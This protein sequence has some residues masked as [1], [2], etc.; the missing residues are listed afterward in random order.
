MGN[1]AL[2]AVAFDF[3]TTYSGYAFSF[4]NDPLNVQHNQ[5]WIAGSDRLISVKTPTCV[6]LNPS[7]QFDSFGY[8]AENNYAILA[9]NNKHHGWLLFRRFKMILHSS[10]VN[11]ITKCFNLNTYFLQHYQFSI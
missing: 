2:L 3:G 9:E 10:Q 7:G 1:S 8:E 11:L 5:G 4:R 6:L